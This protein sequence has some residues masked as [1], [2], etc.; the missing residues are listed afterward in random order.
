MLINYAN[1]PK[2][3]E[4]TFKKI[5]LTGID[6]AMHCNFNNPFIVC[7]DS[8]CLK[9]KKSQNYSHSIINFCYFTHNSLNNNKIKMI[10]DAIG[11][12]KG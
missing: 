6:L 7:T 10:N 5:D 1:L 3:R 2:E 12:V 8:E 9:R 11:T 4:N